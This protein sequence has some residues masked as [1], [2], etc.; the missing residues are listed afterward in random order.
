MRTFEMCPSLSLRLEHS[1]L[2]IIHPHLVKEKPAHVGL[3]VIEIVQQSLRL[4]H[5]NRLGFFCIQ[6]P[7]YHHLG[8]VFVVIAYQTF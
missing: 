1:Y 5:H 7:F 4:D 8:L 6:L 3:I 2:F